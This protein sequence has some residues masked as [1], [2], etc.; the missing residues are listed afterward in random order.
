[1][2]QI[3][4]GSFISSSGQIADNIITLAKIGGQA[5]EGVLVYDASGNPAFLAGGSALEALRENAGGT[6][7]EF[8]LAGLPITPDFES[9]EQTVGVD[10]VLDVAHSLGEIPGFVQVVM[11][12]KTAQHG[13]SI[14]D[15]MPLGQHSG[16]SAD[17]G[18]TIYSD[19]TNVT[20]VQGDGIQMIADDDLNLTGITDGSWRWVVRAWKTT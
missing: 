15:E 8:G 12:C 6:A 16:Y 17:A 14:N 20:V 13:F 7:L 18:V 10:T 9:A 11:R 3:N 19:A 1:M 5:G 4:P 2:P